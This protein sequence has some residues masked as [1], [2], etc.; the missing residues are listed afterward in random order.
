M[1]SAV[2]VG[3][4]RCFNLR[5]LYHWVQIWDGHPN[6]HP[7]Y[8]VEQILQFLVCMRYRRLSWSWKTPRRTSRPWSVRLLTSPALT[9]AN[10]SSPIIVHLRNVTSR[11]GS[12]IFAASISAFQWSPWSSGKHEHAGR[13]GWE[14]WRNKGGKTLVELAEE[15]GKMNCHTLLL[16][17]N[18]GNVLKFLEIFGIYTEIFCLS[19]IPLVFR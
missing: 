3:S 6:E 18:F 1:R 11:S 10:S 19:V 8:P 9:H 17:E 7:S 12:Q 4:G 14:S 15:R 2:I 16:K 13:A 5:D